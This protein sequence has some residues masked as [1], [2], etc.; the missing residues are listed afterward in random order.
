MWFNVLLRLALAEPGVRGD[1]GTLRLAELGLLG[2]A[3]GLG[4]GHVSCPDSGSDDGNLILPLGASLELEYP[5]LST[6]ST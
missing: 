2:L 1:L 3:M 5:L 6:I 4:T